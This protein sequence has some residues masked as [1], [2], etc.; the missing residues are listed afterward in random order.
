MSEPNG[1]RDVAKRLAR[2]NSRGRNNSGV[3]DADS[4]S[5]QA[6]FCKVQGRKVGEE[7]DS[8]NRP[9]EVP[10]PIRFGS[11]ASRLADGSEGAG[12]RPIRQGDE[13]ARGPFH[14][15]SLS[16][17][18]VHRQRTRALHVHLHRLLLRSN[19]C[20]SQHSDSRGSLDSP[21]CSRVRRSRHYG[22]VKEAEELSRMGAGYRRGVRPS[23][24]PSKPKES[25][26]HDRRGTRLG[27]EDGRGIRQ[28]A[29]G[30]NLDLL[31]SEDEARERRLVDGTPPQGSVGGRAWT[32]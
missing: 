14:L 10:N 20:R 32:R 31:S 3:R 11:G 6:S 21:T 29:G 4:L 22:L 18:L 7:E 19:R 16:R 8:N 15:F 27:E 5:S 24:N 25:S 12:C 30:P 17:P 13:P 28:L 2:A 9:S 26:V 23:W 1:V